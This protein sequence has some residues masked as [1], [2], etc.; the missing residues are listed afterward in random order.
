MSSINDKMQN[1]GGTGLSLS[2]ANIRKAGTDI[3]ALGKALGMDTMQ[4][5]I[6][7]AIIH[8]SLL[9]GDG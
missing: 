4:V 2:P 9:E 7:T 5:L 3:R 1:P 8:N 6:L